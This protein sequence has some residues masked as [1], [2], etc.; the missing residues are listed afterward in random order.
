VKSANDIYQ[1]QTV[2]IKI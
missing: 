1:T 2:N